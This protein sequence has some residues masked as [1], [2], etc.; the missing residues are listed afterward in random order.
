V[1]AVA[2]TSRTLEG[3]V[4]ALESQQA[5]ARLVSEYSH[6][7]DRREIDRFMAIW[8]DEAVYDLAEFGGRREGLDAIRAAVH[9]LW[10][11]SAA[12]HHWMVNLAVDVDVDEDRAAGACHALAFDVDAE[13]QV[14]AVALTYEDAFERRDGRWGFV[15]RRV[16]LHRLVPLARRTS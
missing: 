13:E 5:I 14:T 2:G 7:F 8:H 10:T 15:S 1:S 6:G 4:D 16:V 3:R 9:E 12:A 11:A